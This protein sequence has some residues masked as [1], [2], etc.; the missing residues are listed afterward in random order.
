MIEQGSGRIVNLSSQA[1]FVALPGRGGLLHDEGRDLA[2][3]QV[4]GGRVGQARDHRQRGRADVHRHA[5]DRAGARRPGLPR[6]TWRSASP[7]CTASA[8]R[9]T[10]PGAVVFL[11][12]PA[13]SLITGA[14]APRRRRLDGAM[15]PFTLP[16]NVLRHFYAGGERIAALR[17]TEPADHTPEEWIGAANTTFDG[18]RGLSRLPDGTAGA[19]RAR[20]RPG[21][22]PRP[23]A[24]RA[25]SAPTPRCWSSC[26]T[27]GSACPVHFH[28]D[29][30]F[31]ARELGLAHGK[32]EAWLIVE[33]D[34]G[35]AGPGRLHA[36]RRA[37]RGP[38]AG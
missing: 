32:T 17:G 9:T 6:A 35:A 19:R 24:R 13:A 37:R 8:R 10:S 14:D 18:S 20:G 30:E 34:P 28:P 2:P 15:R 23:G 38:R 21:G 22:V 16:P 33:A 4:P 5:R 36:R 29:R 12:S 11:A 1:G 25:A 3:D 7:R 31:A 27:P 26:S